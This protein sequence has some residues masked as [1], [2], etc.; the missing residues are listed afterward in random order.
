[1]RTRLPL[2]QGQGTRGVALSGWTGGLAPQ[3]EAEPRKRAPVSSSNSSSGTRER[4]YALAALEQEATKVSTTPKGERNHRLNRAAFSLGQLV[5]AGHL[6]EQEATDALLD[7]ADACGLGK[8]ESEQTIASGLGAGMKEPRRLP[9]REQSNGDIHNAGSGIVNTEPPADDYEHDDGDAPDAEPSAQIEERLPPAG[10]TASTAATEQP[11]DSKPKPP[12]VVWRDVASIFSPLPPT[13]WLVRDLHICPGRPTMTAAYG[14]SAK[15][16]KLQSLSLSLAAGVPVW[17]QFDAGRFKVKW[18]DHEQ[19]RHATDKRFQ[20]LARGMDIDPPELDGYLFVATFP[21]LY[22]NDA[23][24]VDEYCRAVDGAD[25]VVLDALRGATP[26]MDEN[27]SKIRICID[28][29]TRVSEKTGAAF[30]II[31]H[32]GK[33]K[34]GHSDSRTVA[35]GSS[36][37]FDA[38][39]TVFVVTGLKGKPKRVS[40]QKTAAEAEGASLDDFYLEI[41]DVPIGINPTGGVRVTYRATEAVDAQP[42]AEDRF[43]ADATKIIEYVRANPG[44]SQR[45]ARAKCGVAAG[46]AD[47][48]IDALLEEGRLTDSP[49]K[50]RGRVLEVPNG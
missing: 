23:K 18:L 26:G 39:G 37:I 33:P 9:E 31:H 16:L 17:D 19:G 42:S 46:R 43:E 13:K 7:A 49:G 20:R 29:L 1:V 22:L 48:V 41:V 6:T 45:T 40:Q 4:K 12:R 44:C 2:A 14:H 38:C 36:A 15:S 25:L 10:G 27:D 5:G 30:W 24:A 34:D 47:T 3:T 50:T 28:N 21:D 8:R 11:S 35:R 32:A